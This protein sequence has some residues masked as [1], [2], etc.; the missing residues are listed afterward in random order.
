MTT[1]ISNSNIDNLTFLI[2]LKLFNQK[3]V[4][5]VNKLNQL[6]NIVKIN[7]LQM[8]YN[9]VVNHVNLLN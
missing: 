5:N 3:F 4:L 8:D 6:Q 1:S 9:I 7:Q 2:M